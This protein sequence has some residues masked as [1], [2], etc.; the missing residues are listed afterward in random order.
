MVVHTL[1]SIVARLRTLL[2]AWGR[3]VNEDEIAEAQ[4]V[5]G[6]QGPKLQPSSNDTDTAGP[7]TSESG[8]ADMQSPR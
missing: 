1:R 4:A 3:P 7:R 6:Q 2:H 8:G 5:A